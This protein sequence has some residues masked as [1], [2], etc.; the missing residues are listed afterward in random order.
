MKRHFKKSIIRLNFIVSLGFGLAIGIVFP[1]YARIFVNFKS[2]NLRNLFALSSIVAGL[3]VGILAFII[4]RITILKII[5][6][7]SDEMKNIAQGEAD[8]TKRINVDSEDMIGRFVHFFNMFM[9][10]ICRIIKGIRAGSARIEEIRTSLSLSSDTTVNTLTSCTADIE[11]VIEKFADFDQYID[12][13]N[14]SVEQI[15]ESVSRLNSE[16]ENQT[17]SV[18]E[19]TA[20]VKQAISSLQTVSDLAAKEKKSSEIL[21]STAEQGGSE[22]E[23][24]NEMIRSIV[25]DIGALLE[26][27]RLIG[28]I[29]SQTSFL[30]M[31]AAIEAAHAGNYGQ[32]FA[33]IAEEVRNL[34]ESTSENA[35]NISTVLKKIIGKIED[36]AKSGESTQSAFQKI[37]EAIRKVAQGLQEISDS[38]FE[39]SEGSREILQAMASLDETQVRIK[40]G[41][42]TI[43]NEIDKIVA[44]MKKVRELSGTML[45][46]LKGIDFGVTNITEAIVSVADASNKLTQTISSLN[47]EVKKFRVSE[48]E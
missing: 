2:V 20:A 12:T 39:L 46:S 26:M 28:S 35:K 14:S 5:G 40:E 22:L 44:S 17:A 37:N 1:F 16:I 11:S 6:I 33:V 24:T 3:I 9:E 29:S 32:G 43:K 25:E 18:M 47:A 30:A 8:L 23:K 41:S 10:K 13:S 27:S 36:T 15:L 31:N 38:A 48:Q 45:K 21:I 19:S 7:L 42:N 34:S 4:T